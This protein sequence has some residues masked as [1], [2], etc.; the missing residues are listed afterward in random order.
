MTAGRR[1]GRGISHGI[2]KS[3]RGPGEG[4]R[5]GRAARDRTRR[6]FAWR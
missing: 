4:G 1:R 2:G 5:S 6:A 3:T